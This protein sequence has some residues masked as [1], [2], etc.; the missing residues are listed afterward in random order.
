[1]GI[2]NQLRDEITDLKKKLNSQVNKNEQQ[3]LKNIII[4]K[5]IPSSVK[6]KADLIKKMSAARE[7]TVGKVKTF[8][9][10]KRNNTD[11]H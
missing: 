8:R 9:L 7:D 4:P 11:H 6:D 2:N 10:G 3:D 5:G 1:M